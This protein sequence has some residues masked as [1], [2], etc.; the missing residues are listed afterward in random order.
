MLGPLLFWFYINGIPQALSNSYT[1]LYAGD[2]SI[3]YQHENVR[4][5]ENVLSKKFAN[6]CDWF[7]NNKLSV[8]FSKDK[9]ECILFSREKT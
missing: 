1:Y 3:F 9:T 2:T 6:V 5:K 7:V 8:Y 4:E